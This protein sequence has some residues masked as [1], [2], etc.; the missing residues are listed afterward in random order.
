MPKPRDESR[1][2]TGHE[3]GLRPLEALDPAQTGSVDALVRAMSRTA[4]GGRRLGRA[5]DVLEAMVRDESCFRVVT[6]AGAMT[7][8]KQ[9]VV[10]CEMIDR[11]WVHAVVTTGALVTHPELQHLLDVKPAGDCGHG[12]NPVPIWS[13]MRRCGL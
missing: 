9:S 4:F 2:G 12:I 8:A 1:Y 11:G 10:L 7:I 3:D 5:A 6:I 13:I